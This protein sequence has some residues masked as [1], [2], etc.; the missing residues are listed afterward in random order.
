MLQWSKL[1]I[2][3]VETLYQCMPGNTK[4]YL[5]GTKVRIKAPMYTWAHKCIPGDI[6]V[7]PVTLMYTL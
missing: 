5:T 2:S 3:H 7:Y 4:V 1:M 6:N